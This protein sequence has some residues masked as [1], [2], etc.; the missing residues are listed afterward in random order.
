MITPAL[1]SVS[2]LPSGSI[3]APAEETS[4]ITGE[5]RSARAL[6]AEATAVCHT[7]KHH[8]E[9]ACLSCNERRDITWD[10]DTTHHGN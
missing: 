4:T 5:D 3:T 1:L 6:D 8:Q 2:P 9:L 7:S 10:T